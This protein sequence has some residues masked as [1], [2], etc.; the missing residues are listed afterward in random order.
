MRISLLI[1]TVFV[2][3]AGVGYV[4]LAP[5]NVA[6][7]GL[8]IVA[9]Y[10]LVLLVGVGIGGSGKA[11]E[12]LHTVNFRMVLVPLSVMIGTFGGVALLAAVVPGIRLRESLAVGA[13]FGYYS[14]SSIIILNI[15]GETLAAVALL[16]NIFREIVTLVTAPLLAKRLFKLAPISIGA[17][18]T[19]DTTLP[20]VTQFTGTEY[21]L[22]CVFNGMALSLAVPFLVP[23][24]L[25]V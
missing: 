17:A 21:A 18:T 4:G 22:I 6:K 8:S 25:T 19:M 12:V 20:I 10:V 5:E 1:L 16:A 2:V 24:I 9:L 7:S 11:A 15:S 23:L 3:G 13:G 14:L